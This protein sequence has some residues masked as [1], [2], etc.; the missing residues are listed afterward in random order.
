MK[1]LL[2][3]FLLLFV[4]A[5]TCLA[6]TDGG[7]PHALIHFVRTGSFAASDCSSEVTLL[8][9]R[10]F[11][12]PLKAIVE[13]TIY[14]EGGIPVTIEI[15]CPYRR[16]GGPQSATRKVFLNVTRGNEYYILYNGTSV[17]AVQ[18]EEAVKYMDKIAQITKLKENL[19]SPINSISLE[20]TAKK[21]STT[22]A[23]CFLI[24]SEGYLITNYHCIEKAKEIIIKGIDG[25][26]TTKY[27]VTVVAI[28][29]S[30]DLALLKLSNKNLR[31]SP[32]PFA[33]KT[34]GI[35]TTEKIYAMGY[36]NDTA[37]EEE[38]QMTE[39]TILAKSSIQ[40]DVSKFQVSAA[41]NAGNSGGPLIDE[42]GNVIGVVN[43]KSAVID[44]AGYAIKASYLDA[45]LKSIEGFA[46]LNYINALK[47]KSLT[48]KTAVLKNYIFMLEIN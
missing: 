34:T 30:N 32:L 40:G 27:A 36:P 39:G 26:F 25:D 10:S 28:D 31:F 12:L 24:S 13:Y 35:L 3:F 7:V 47:S 41:A 17:G 15:K 6:Q 20:T 16:N 4:H 22:H 8:N 38:L 23:T 42:E 11:N 2:Y 33:L 1:H 46:Y 14:S 29:L 21:S 18:K 48:D 44:L 9:Q 19:A 5:T 43:T 45:F 37:K